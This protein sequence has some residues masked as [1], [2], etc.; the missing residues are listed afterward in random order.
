MLSGDGID[1]GA[2]SI[3]ADD[4]VIL[5]R[6][7]DAVMIKG[8]REGMQTQLHHP[9]DII[10]D[11][12]IPDLDEEHPG[13]KLLDLLIG[14]RNGKF[15]HEAKVRGR[16]MCRSKV[17]DANLNRDLQVPG[18]TIATSRN[19]SRLADFDA[20]PYLHPSETRIRIRSFACDFEIP[21]RFQT[22]YGWE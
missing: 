15:G 21:Q 11:L 22:S 7:G 8:Q 1:D 3:L 17:E 6:K 18:E 2:P 20:D 19:V 13:A 5:C 4:W 12:P 9:Q 10:S 16:R 14:G